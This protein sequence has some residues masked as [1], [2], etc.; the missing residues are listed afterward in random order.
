MLTRREHFALLTAAG[1]ACLIPTGCARKAQAQGVV[2]NRA[3]L[4]AAKFYPLPLGSVRPAG[5]LRDQLRIQADGLTGHL[6]EFW[7]SLDP[8]KSGW[9]GAS[10]GESWERGPYYLDGLVPLA[11]L[12]DDQR[13]ID[14]AKSWVSWTIENQRSDGSIGPDPAKGNYAR[15]WQATDWWPNMIMLKVL[16]QYAEASG[17]PRVLPLLEK[18][19]LH[20]LDNA[21]RIPLVEWARVRWAEE[22][23]SIIWVYNRTGNAKLLELARIL[24]TQSY[25]WKA[26]FADFQFPGKVSKEQAKLPTHVVNNAMALKTSAVYWQISGDPADRDSIQ[27]ILDVMDAHHLMPNAVHSGDEHY[28]GNSPVQGTE[29]CAVVEGM[30]SYETLLAILGE[31][32]FG[33]RLEKVAYNALPATLSGDMWS[34]QYDQ[35]PNQVLCTRHPRQWTTNGP[36]SNLFGLEPNFGCCTANYHQG[37]PKFVASLWMATP[38][39][40]VAAMAWGPSE[41][42]APVRGGGTVRIIEETSYPFRGDVKLRIDPSAAA[43][44][45][46]ALRIPAW[47]TGAEVLV[48]GEKLDSVRAGEFCRIERKWES[49]DIVD[50]KFPMA[51]RSS[52]WFHDSIAIERGPLVFSLNVGTEWKKIR[53][54]GQTADYELHPTTPWNYALAIDPANP[55]GLSVAVSD[56]GKMP[57][58]ADTAPVRIE[59]PARK[60]PNWT[61]EDASAAPPPPSPVE[62]KEV[63][64]TVTLIP[65]GSAKLRITAFPWLKA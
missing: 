34:H 5:W 9:R 49:G 56:P 26:H 38:D 20:H 11:Y 29:L 35:Q 14:K 31:A 4:Q 48:N 51:L 52:K 27:Q 30:F 16:T 63:E 62:S 15:D 58:S 3:P 47:A 7:E 59:V 57:F 10:G 17:D 64:E 24:S 44:F 40:G 6:D 37:W 45:P 13:L 18:Y 42:A 43:E 32:R 25:D 61:I 21:T 65:Y 55:Q 1:A 23:L 60:L 46:L 22:V 54:A 2:Q 33:D 28:A 53:D 12:L 8:A 36:D 39:G 41:V 50:V 19:L